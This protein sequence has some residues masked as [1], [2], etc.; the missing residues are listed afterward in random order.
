MRLRSCGEIG[1]GKAPSTL[2]IR[3]VAPPKAGTS[4][5]CSRLLENARKR[6]LGTPPRQLPWEDHDL[7]LHPHL[8]SAWRSP[9]IWGV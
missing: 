6:A 7:S 1:K 3:R 5:G 2:T 8:G 9:I 4:R